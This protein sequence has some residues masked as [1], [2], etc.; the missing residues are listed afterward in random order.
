MPETAGCKS[1][2][3]MVVCSSARLARHRIVA[4]SVL[5]PNGELEFQTAFDEHFACTITGLS[6]KGSTDLFAVNRS[7][8]TARLR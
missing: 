7:G 1:C 2:A 5:P 4:V 3:Y 8:D 6:H